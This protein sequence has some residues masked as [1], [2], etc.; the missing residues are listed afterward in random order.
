MSDEDQ[1]LTPL[2]E[3]VPH[4]PRARR[5]DP[6]Y[7]RQSK[8][9]DWADCHHV[10]DSLGTSSTILAQVRLLLDLDLDAAQIAK[11]SDIPLRS[12]NRA[13][14]R[15]YFFKVRRAK[16]KPDV[17]RGRQLYLM[18][19]VIALGFR[20]RIILDRNGQPVTEAVLDK[21]GNPVLEPGGQVLK[22]PLTELPSPAALGK[23]IAAVQHQAAILGTNAPTLSR[24][25][26]LNVEAH[27]IDPDRLRKVLATAEGREALLTL[28][29]LAQQSE[30]KEIVIGGGS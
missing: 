9:R 3:D 30:S 21:D 18:D 26:N 12:V 11:V 7:V 4:Q 8:R 10:Q 14:Q 13:I 17:E 25:E 2:N 1:E 16:K 23:V 6:D 5:G 15:I 27:L 28:E 24:T 29:R 19:R 20:E 22:R